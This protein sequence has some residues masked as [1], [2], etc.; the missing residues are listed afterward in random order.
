LF[1]IPELPL[2]EVAASSCDCVNNA[3]E[4][5]ERRRRRYGGGEEAGS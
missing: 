4:S 1:Y 2:V 3:D 5:V